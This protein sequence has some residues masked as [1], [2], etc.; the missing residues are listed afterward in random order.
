MFMFKSSTNVFIS[1]VIL[2]I[3]VVLII[4]NN[5]SNYKYLCPIYVPTPPNG[6]SISKSTLNFGCHINRNS[7][8]SRCQLH[9]ARYVE[10]MDDIA[11]II[12]IQ[13]P[14]IV[15]NVGYPLNHSFCEYPSWSNVGR[16]AFQYISFILD[17]YE[18]P[19]KLGEINIFCQSVPN[20][21]TISEFQRN[22]D[23]ICPLSSTLNL[24]DG[25]AFM[26]EGDFQFKNGWTDFPRNY[27]KVF[28]HLFNSSILHPVPLRYA[29][30]HT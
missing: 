30:I 21:I 19:H 25:F 3:G 16:E 15:L 9:F 18:Y 23:R 4:I 5:S 27:A 13:H 10:S 11:W 8:N 7:S 6:F 29:C 1:I 14:S 20:S 26:G 2:I 28:K 22:V 17:H 12:R 24:K